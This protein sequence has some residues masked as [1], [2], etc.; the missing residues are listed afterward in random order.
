MKTITIDDEIY[1]KLLEAKKTLGVRSFSQVLRKILT[2][3]R[4]NWVYQL[5]GKIDIDEKEIAKLEKKWE[6]WHTQ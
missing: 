3:D 6:E 1:N 5:A 4:I 2:E